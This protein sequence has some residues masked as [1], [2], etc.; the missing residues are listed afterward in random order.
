MSDDKYFE[1]R[2]MSEKAV[3]PA[4]AAPHAANGPVTRARYDGTAGEVARIALSNALFNLLTLGIYRFWAKTRL[5]G[6]F[7][8]SVR[9]HGDRLEYT[10][11][12]G[13]LFVGFI[14]AFA[15]LTVFVL[16]VEA[17]TA[18]V[19]ADTTAA[20]VI[21][22]LQGLV[23]FF[24]IYVAVFRARRYRLTRTQWRGIRGGQSGS[25]ATFALM[26]LGWMLVVLLTLGRGLGVS[27]MPKNDREFR[28][29]QLRQARRQHA[30]GMHG[31][32]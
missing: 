31:S 25:S 29:A 7:W 20:G 11:R 23:F 19:G 15:I 18:M 8:P 4:G 21:G 16:A 13:E 3:E 17:I 26:A 6:Y 12:A 24:L 1:V 30:Y 14:V 22:L 27:P 5:R 10:G 28:R 32:R 2:A 9:L